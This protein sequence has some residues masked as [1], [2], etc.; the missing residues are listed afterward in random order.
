V[1]VAGHG[2]REEAAV[3]RRAPS[4]S[5]DS[6]A[7]QPVRERSANTLVVERSS[8]RVKPQVVR[9]EQRHR[10]RRRLRGILEIG[11]RFRPEE[12]VVAP[13]PP[14]VV[15]RL[16]QGDLYL[17]DVPPRPMPLGIG[18]EQRLL[19]PELPENEGP[20]ADQHRPRAPGVSDFLDTVAWPRE[21]G[22]ERKQ[23]GEVRTGLLE[24]KLERAP[25]DGLGLET[26]HKVSC[27]DRLLLHGSKGECEVL[28]RDRLAVAPACR[29]SE[30]QP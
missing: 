6:V 9:P 13:G 12:K 11:H 15:R 30:T 5:N 2:R 26:H 4:A 14:V 20:V 17:G 19:A 25:V 8:L 29:L 7:V 16:L 10:E 21:E 24:T 28:G 3:R 27:G 18:R 22:R 23:V 1:R